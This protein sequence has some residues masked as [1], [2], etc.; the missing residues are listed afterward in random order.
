[1]GP[2]DRADRQRINDVLADFHVTR[3][4]L[5]GVQTAGHRRAYIDQLLESVR[6]VR[7][8]AVIRQRP[9]DARRA[10]PDSDLFDPHKGAAYLACHGQLDEAFW[11]VFI[12]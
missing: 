10:D 6:R 1:M 7:Y 4:P 8:I 2:S 3:Y 12:S 11:Q 9:I 5:P